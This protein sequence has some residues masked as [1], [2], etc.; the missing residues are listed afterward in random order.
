M[1]KMLDIRPTCARSLCMSVRYPHLA[2]FQHWASGGSSSQI[3]E[4]TLMALMLVSL[5]TGGVCEKFTLL[6]RTAYS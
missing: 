1:R 2:S 4:Y 5:Q 3:R 6:V